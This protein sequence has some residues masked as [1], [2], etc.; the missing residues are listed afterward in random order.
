MKTKQFALIILATVFTLSAVA[1]EFPK[2]EVVE[3]DNSKALVKAVTDNSG[4]ARIS[5][6]S[7]EGDLLYHKKVKADSE[8]ETILNLSELEEGKYTIKLN[9]GSTTVQRVVEVNQTDVKPLEREMEPFFS[10]NN[11]KLILSYLNFN[12]TDMSVFVYKGSQLLFRTELGDDFIMQRLFEISGKEKGNLN[13]VLAGADKVY[14][15][16]FKR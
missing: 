3:V 8:F 7:E 4:S 6:V 10:Y 13:F 11:D 2:M 5:V 12:Q 15:Y 9:D 1:T 16:N 14:S